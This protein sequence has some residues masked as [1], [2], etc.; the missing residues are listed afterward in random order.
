MET[1]LCSISNL[2]WQDWAAAVGIIFGIITLL[3]YLDQRRA[4]KKQNTL[5]EFVK[6]HVDKEVTEE[7]IRKLDAQREA[8]QRQVREHI[9][10]L[11]RSAVLREQ[12]E[13]H[14]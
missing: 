8:L 6:R 14:A 13:A 4:N 5:I 12:A 10:A 7:T 2:K 11:A 3:A 9:P 1:I